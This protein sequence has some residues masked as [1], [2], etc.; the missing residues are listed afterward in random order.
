[1]NR[2]VAR[3]TERSEPHGRGDGAVTT[4]VNNPLKF[5]GPTRNS[6]N[7]ATV[8]DRG[9]APC[10]NKIRSP[11]CQYCGVSIRTST[12]QITI[13]HVSEWW[14]IRHASRLL[15]S[16][17]TQ[18]RRFLQFF[19]VAPGSSRFAECLAWAS[20]EVRQLGGVQARMDPGYHWVS[21][22]SY[23]RSMG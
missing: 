1:M 15:Q 16:A 13:D 7:L 21:R 6:Q 19:T 2:S 17:Y 22:G 5:L 14:H 20:V 11:R 9:L 3:F 4:P 18:V 23:V 12:S 8:V 10:A